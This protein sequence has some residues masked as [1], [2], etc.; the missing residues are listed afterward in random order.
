VYSVAFDPQGKRLATVGGDKLVKVWDT[1]TGELLNTLSGHT[2]LVWDVA[3]SPDGK[4]IGT[5]SRDGTAKIWDATSGKE[6]LT[7][8]GHTGIVD[9]IAFSWDG[10]ARIWSVSTGTELISFLVDG[11]VA[12]MS[13]SQ[14]GRRFALKGGAGGIYIFVLPV[15]DL[16]ALAKSRVT[17]SL[18]TEE[19]EQYLH[20]EP[21]PSQP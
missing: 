6:L 3:Y 17:R 5:A 11:P 2:D 1:R 9:S 16:V 12:G 13:F 20:M 14:D 4:L 15:D 19:C 18:T 7:L 10:S 21:C 8:R